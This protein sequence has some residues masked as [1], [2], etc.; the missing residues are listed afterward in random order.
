MVI[1]I[2]GPAGAGKSTVAR[3]LA[4]ELEFVFLNSGSFY[5]AVAYAA[6]QKNTNLE[7]ENALVSLA[8]A[9]EIEYKNGR[10]FLAG[11]D[12]EDEIHTEKIGMMTSKISAIPSLRHVVNAKMKAAVG[13]QSIVCEGRDMTT[14]VFPDAD[15]K[16][17]LDAALD[18]QAQRR[19]EEYKAKGI[20]ADL[21]EIR[22]QIAERDAFDKNKKEGSLLRA[23]DAHY[24]DTSHLSIDQVCEK[25][26]NFL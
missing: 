13:N 4:R 14:V 15:C 5:R 1:A 9:L 19:F 10:I 26:K 25:I 20:A 8:S 24:I 16:I 23:P 12:V 21:S 3:R 6:A 7:D 11:Q 22:A 17:Y 18:V 2:D